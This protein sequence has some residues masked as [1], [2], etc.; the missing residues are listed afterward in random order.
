[1][2]LEIS[3]GGYDRIRLEIINKNKKK[4]KKNVEIMKKKNMRNKKI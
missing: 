2:F 3:F 1:M 4:N